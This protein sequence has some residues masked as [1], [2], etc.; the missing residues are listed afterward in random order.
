MKTLTTYRPP[1][2]VAN[3]GST[4]ALLGHVMLLVAAAIGS[5]AA[6]AFIGRGL[7]PGTAIVASFVA[8]GMLI[9]QA[10]GG[11]R[12]RV[13]PFAV[14]WLLAVGLVLGLGLGPVLVYYASADPTALLSAGVATAG[15]V[16]AV[17]VGGYALDKDLAGWIKPLALVIFG[18]VVLSVVLLLAGSDGGPWLSLVI[19]IASALLILVDFNYLRRHGTEDDAVLLATGIFVSVVNIFLS[20]LNLFSRE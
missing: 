12:Y 10:F 14:A 6:G 5:S 18:V 19:A 15:V 7:T 16:A 9:V 4:A 20:L 2:R 3:S 13:G 8:F 11:E 17:G 1:P